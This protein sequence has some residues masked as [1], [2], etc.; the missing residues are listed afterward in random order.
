MG[1]YRFKNDLKPSAREQGYKFEDDST[2]KS[3]ERKYR[4][5]HDLIEIFRSL[6]GYWGLPFFFKAQNWVEAK[7]FRKNSADNEEYDFGSPLSLHDG[8][9]SSLGVPYYAENDSGNEVFLPIWLK[10]PGKE[11]MLL[12]NTVSSLTNRKTIVETALVNRQGTVKEEIAISDWEINVKGIMVDPHPNI[13]PESKVQALLD[14]YKSGVPVC[15]DNVRT[16]MAIPVE[17][18]G[19]K[20]IADYEMV[21]VRDLKLPEVRGRQNCQAFEMNLVSDLSFDL[22]VE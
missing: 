12:E 6:W 1:N 11:W 17:D 16:A 19:D 9:L 2:K 5:E 15:I 22:Y 14:L 4:F 7:M 21:V 13:Y 8:V 3:Y 10:P 20:N 18:N